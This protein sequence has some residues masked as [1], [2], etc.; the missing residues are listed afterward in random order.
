MARGA[1]RLAGRALRG[2]W[3]FLAG[4]ALVVALGSGA[5]IGAA[6]AAHRTNHAYG[7]YVEAA[8]VAELVVNP[9][10]R[11]AAMDEAIRRFDGVEEV[12]VDSLLLGSFSATGPISLE[13]APDDESWLQ[14]RGTVD[15]RY[16][17]LDR[18]VIT[19]GELPSGDREVFISDDYRPTLEAAQ[20]RSLE[21]G[22]TIDMGFY[23]AG[24]FDAGIDPTE[25]IEPIGVEHLRISGFGVL[26]NEVL[27]EELFP[28]EQ[29]IVSEDV[30]NRY[31]CLDDI[32]PGVANIDEIFAAL[33]PADCAVSYDYYSLRLRDGTQ[34]A[35]SIRLQ[36]QEAAAELQS[37]LPAA[38][39]DLDFGY[40]YV[41]QERADIDEAVRETIQPTVTALQAFAIVAALATLT[42]AG[43][44]VARQAGRHVGV[45]QSLRALGTTRVEMTL[46]SVAPLVVVT[47]VGLAGGVVVALLVSP[48]GP[49][50]TVRSVAPS[51]GMS[52]PAA[53]AL[54]LAGLLAAA[55][56]LVFA[57]VSARASWRTAAADRAP[58]AR[59]S[60]LARLVGGGRPALSTGV[61]AAVDGRRGGAG[62]AAMLGCAVAT[63]AAAGAIVFG[64]S[65]SELV[66]DPD[67]YGWPWDIAVITGAGYGD[68]IM[69]A[70]D[71][72]LARDD[73]RDDVVDRAF[74]GFDPA[75]VI[76][77]QPAPAIFSLA[78][79]GDVELPVLEGRMPV[80]A[81]EALLGSET[82][83]ALGLDVGDRTTITSE[84]FGEIDLE[85][86]AI[87]VLPSVGSFGA[88]RTN[89]GDGVYIVMEP[90]GDD[91]TP[92]MT[93]MWVRDG[94]DADDVLE[95]MGPEL[96]SFSVL[97]EP[98]VTHT[99]PVRSPEI[100]NAA[101]LRRAPLVLGGVLLGSLALAL[102][103]A[104]A[105]S[106]RDRRRELAV[107]RALGFSDRDL[108]QSIRWQG[109][110]LLAGGLV[111]GI[112]LGIVAGRAA[113]EAFSDRLGL[114][115]NATVPASWL[116]AEV[117]LTLVL[118]AIAV[119]LPARAAARV[120]P[121]EELQVP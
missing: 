97:G 40:F 55:L 21:V 104:V 79:E 39:T 102:G 25:T 65:L 103:L 6:V 47:L 15:G 7:D 5:S 27:P 77:D 45:R 120:S 30:A 29:V 17:D 63:A 42:V 61:G 44:M 52:L 64:A 89:L 115:P 113:W 18:P 9:S 2:G 69:D 72:R 109:L 106:V 60:R 94:V 13:E 35:T 12:R 107:L 46:W 75:L 96:P 41:S 119:A 68:T 3:G 74:F 93:A 16:L 32:D 82:A 26:A 22:D 51:P 95:R 105:L 38:V 111:V 117:A 1:G 37:A 54:P 84:E 28:R 50:G 11:T 56:L 53:V 19:D 14:V 100:V 92:G 31:Y 116:A 66:D 91:Y 71:D 73:L 110:V 101:E 48:V 67:E 36:F 99:T 112:P 121:A 90:P 43:L 8:E 34:G 76:E 4:L 88:D 49:L 83:R 58:S 23:W 62:A 10:I 70:V 114:V 33:L 85:V 86:T 87:G 118:G 78:G 57:L 80:D 59:T 81:G 98:P 108:R 20:G 24:I